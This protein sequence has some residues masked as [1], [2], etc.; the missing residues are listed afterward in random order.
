MQKICVVQK[1]FH[2]LRHPLVQRLLALLISLLLAMIF[3]CATL[4]IVLPRSVLILRPFPTVSNLLASQAPL[5]QMN[6]VGQV[7]EQVTTH[8]A[9]KHMRGEQA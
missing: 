3:A 5:P 6:V 1:T 4:A 2:F 8:R 9:G 7:S